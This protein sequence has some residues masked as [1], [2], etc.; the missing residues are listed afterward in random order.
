[1]EAEFTTK[2]CRRCAELEGQLNTYVTVSRAVSD[3][4]D[5]AFSQNRTLK[6]WLEWMS[7]AL[8]CL[9]GITLYLLIN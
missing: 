6:V 1:M 4:R 2:R 3:A 8:V 5:Y 7:F 9:S